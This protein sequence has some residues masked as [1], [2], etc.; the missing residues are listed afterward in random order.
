MVWSNKKEGRNA[1][2]LIKV[3]FL[4][5]LMHFLKCNLN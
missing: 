2:L 3:L 4:I 5:G 1:Q